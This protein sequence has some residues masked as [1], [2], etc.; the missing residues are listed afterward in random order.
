[1]TARAIR[2]YGRNPCRRGGCR[3]RARTVDL[4]RCAGWF[5]AVI[6]PRVAVTWEA[7]AVTGVIHGG[8]VIQLQWGRLPEFHAASRSCFEV[9]KDNGQHQDPK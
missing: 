7:W 1:M 6:R 4:V 2:R 3:D 8:K 9:Q 5:N